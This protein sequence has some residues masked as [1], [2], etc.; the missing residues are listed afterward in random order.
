MR[1]AG[2]Q[3]HRF[4]AVPRLP[5]K[6]QA[7]A[8]WQVSRLELVS[9][10]KHDLPVAY[11]SRLLPRMDQLADSPTRTL[12]DF[13]K[14]ALERLRHDEDLVIQDGVQRIRMVG[15]IRA[16]KD[17]LDCHS[18]DRGHLLGAFT[19]ELVP[20]QPRGKRPA[21]TSARPPPPL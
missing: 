17:C 19:Y 12:D 21:E 10:L 7:N 14:R 5:S 11:V 16:A 6:D 15:S 18:V 4:L 9:L 1:V 20:E 13:E 8:Q 2:F 3:S